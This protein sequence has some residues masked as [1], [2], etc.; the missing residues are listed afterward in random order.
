M[1]IGLA[2]SLAVMAD[3]GFA[4][5]LAHRTISSDAC[6]LFLDAPLELAL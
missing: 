5:L 6:G 3:A 1:Q 2:S 4:N